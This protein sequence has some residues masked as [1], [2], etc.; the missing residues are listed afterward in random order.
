MA[1]LNDN[2]FNF[3]YARKAVEEKR[4]YNFKDDIAF[5]KMATERVN[6]KKRF[7]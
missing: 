2:F 6:L 7:L 3:L 1:G 5:A 4:C